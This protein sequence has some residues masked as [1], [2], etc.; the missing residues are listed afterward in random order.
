MDFIPR[1]CPNDECPSRARAG[2]QWTRRGSY[3]RACD[4]RVVQRFRCKHCGRC[5]S[6]QSFRVD[7]RLKRP[8]L[9]LVL[10]RDFVSKITHRQ[11]AR[12][13]GCSRKTV[14]H[15]LRLLGEHCRQLHEAILARGV[16]PGG[17]DF[18][19]DELET[20]EE[21]RRLQPV[22][23][24]ILIERRRFV[25]GASVGALPARG[26]L[27]PEEERKKARLEARRGRRRNES[28]AAV[29]RTLEYLARF[30]GAAVGATI[31]SDSKSTYPRLIRQVLGPGV[32]HEQHSSTARRD[33][34]N[35]LFPINHTLA[36]FR[37]GISRLVRR[38]WAAAKRRERLLDH[39]WIW[40]AWRNYV[41]PITN[42]SGE[43]TP[44]MGLGLLARPLSAVSLT[45]WRAGAFRG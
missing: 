1:H 40:I 17:L 10:L 21:W 42:E 18:Q 33:C 36:M 4:R 9:H 2:F 31:A 25:V 23:V 3:T 20:F 11:S 5:F 45:C 38:S 24:P 15:R 19:L 30:P 16:A 28:R 6:T 27:R 14:A 12:T 35:P 43:V 8:Q 13:L 32:R 22:T 29:A 41:R 26:R 44:A 39:L 37:D 34:S 7:Y